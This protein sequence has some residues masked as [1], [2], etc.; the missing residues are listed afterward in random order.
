MATRR[1]RVS[2][3]AKEL[4]VTPTVVLEKLAE[5]GEYVR[6]SASVIEPPVA[7]AIRL[8]FP[9]AG[10]KQA[11]V[12]V[13]T[14][15]V[16]V[17]RAQPE[18]QPRSEAAAGGSCL[19]PVPPSLRS[20][21]RR[22]EFY[23][24]EPP[25]DFMRFILDERVMPRRDPDYRGKLPPNGGYFEDEVREARTLAQQWAPALL[26][27]LS[28]EVIGQWINLGWW[29]GR[30][31]VDQAIELA[32]ADVSPDDIRYNDDGLGALINRLWLGV[33]TPE[34]IIA[35]VR[36]RRKQEAPSNKEPMA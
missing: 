21:R 20:T 10:P 34:E 28:F 26:A 22:R 18:R 13:G 30:L 29:G 11:P 33:A 7:E 17:T 8:A 24:G 4:G 5:L 27:G 36:E 1:V 15:A 19:P 3:L 31:K 23:R 12:A 2:V 32:L 35:I 6:S 16:A 14:S 25:K 9:S